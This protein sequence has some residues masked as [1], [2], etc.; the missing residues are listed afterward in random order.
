M[1]ITSALVRKG[2]RMTDT[3]DILEF[4]EQVDKVCSECQEFDCYGCQ[5]WKWRYKNDQCRTI[6]ED[7]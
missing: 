3:T 5:Y 4:I 2:K 1:V 7:I 6:Q